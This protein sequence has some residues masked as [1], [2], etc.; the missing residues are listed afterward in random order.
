MINQDVLR[1]PSALGVIGL[2]PEQPACQPTWHIRGTLV[3]CCAHVEVI[4][5]QLYPYYRNI[6][7]ELRLQEND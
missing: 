4:Y 6:N 3:P 1:L 7:S 5:R 2:L